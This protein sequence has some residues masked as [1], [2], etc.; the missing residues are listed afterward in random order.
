MALSD[1]AAL[2]DM[3]GW[4]RRLTEAPHIWQPERWIDLGNQVDW[5]GRAENWKSFCMTKDP[6][7]IQKVCTSLGAESTETKGGSVCCFSSSAK[8]SR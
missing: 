7:K 1:I 8:I 2:S 6:E 4:H 3:A 5:T